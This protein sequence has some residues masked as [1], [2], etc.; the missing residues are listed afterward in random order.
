MFYIASH[1]LLSP[2]DDLSHG[3]WLIKNLGYRSL[4][5]LILFVVSHYLGRKQK[6][7]SMQGGLLSQGHQGNR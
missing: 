7:S 3:S 4:S 2:E 6:D 5:S 1:F